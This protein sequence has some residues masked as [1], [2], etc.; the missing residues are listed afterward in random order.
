[1]VEEVLVIGYIWKSG[2]APSELR[3]HFTAGKL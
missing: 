1:M 3:R 2:T